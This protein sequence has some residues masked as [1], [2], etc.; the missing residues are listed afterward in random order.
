MK[1]YQIETRDAIVDGV[2]V[3]PICGAS[4]DGQVWDFVSNLWSKSLFNCKHGYAMFE[5][6]NPDEAGSPYL[7]ASIIYEE[8]IPELE[9]LGYEEEK[10]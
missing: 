7:P 10:C 3:C 5:N 9:A 8:F 2:E 1:I 4:T 6:S